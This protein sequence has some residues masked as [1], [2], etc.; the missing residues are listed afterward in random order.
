M[1]WPVHLHL[2]TLRQD[3]VPQVP[4]SFF[5]YCLAPLSFSFFFPP[6]FA[7]ISSVYPLLPLATIQH[8]LLTSHANAQP[9]TTITTPLPYT[10]ILISYVSPSLCLHLSTPHLAVLSTPPIPALLS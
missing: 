4:S 8:H 3:V 1:H 5:P 6:V 9:M 2:Q 10:S 7:F